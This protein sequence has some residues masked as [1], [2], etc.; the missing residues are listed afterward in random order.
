MSR[1]GKEWEEKYCPSPRE[2]SGEEEWSDYNPTMT[3]DERI[4]EVDEEYNPTP[5]VEDTGGEGMVSRSES[6]RSDDD[7]IE[8]ERKRKRS[9]SNMSEDK[10]E[11][12]VG[13][14]AGVQKDGVF[15]EPQKVGKFV[16]KSIG[17]VVLVRITRTGMVIIQ[18]KDEEQEEKAIQMTTF[19]KCPVKCF[20]L[21]GRE[22]RRGVISVPLTVKENVFLQ[23][24]GVSEV[25]RLT[26]FKNGEREKTNSVQVIF[27]GNELPERIYCDY[28]SYRVRPYVRAPL[29]CFRCQDYGHVAAVCGNNIHCG[30]CGKDNCSMEKCKEE[31]ARC[32]HCSG[33]H[34]T[35]AAECPRKI[36]EAEVAKIREG[37]RGQMSYAEAVRRVEGSRRGATQAEVESAKEET[38]E[39]NLGVNVDKRNFLAF[40]A[41]VIN[42]AADI[43]SKSERIKMVLDAAK[44]FLKVVDVSGEDLDYT[45]REGLSS[46]KANGEEEKD[47]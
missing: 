47:E 29:R 41:M 5:E 10:R 40:I 24:S 6:D 12:M 19:G 3:E 11:Y 9:E 15:S 37:A 33:N 23:V 44:R 14:I 43:K 31:Q 32:L 36:Q 13:M 30:R 38:R 34:F 27:K 25:R 46:N 35:G 1:G 2:D 17:K 20:R 39:K 8:R 18:C 16:E 4:W 7:E 26:R 42:C 21:G 28:M 45:L 22:R